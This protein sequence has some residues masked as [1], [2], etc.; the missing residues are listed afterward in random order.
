MSS[1]ERDQISKR[2]AE[3]SNVALAGAAL[4]AFVL[5]H[6]TEL[7][8]LPVF[9]GDALRSLND[10]ESRIGVPVFCCLCVCVCVLFVVIRD[11]QCLWQ[12]PTMRNMQSQSLQSDTY[13][14]HSTKHCKTIRDALTLNEYSLSK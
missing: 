5:P 2:A 14:A 6:L 8:A 9:A 3:A 7:V 12:D 13:S 4:R 1:S 10:H 11:V